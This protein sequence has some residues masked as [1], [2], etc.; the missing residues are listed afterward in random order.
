MNAKW[1][2]EGRKKIS[3]ILYNN[4]L[5]N[6]RLF[7]KNPF[8]IRS[9]QICTSNVHTKQI[10]RTKRWGILYRVWSYLYEKLRENKNKLIKY[11]E[12][13][14]RIPIENHFF[15]FSTKN[16]MKSKTTRLHR[17]YT[18]FIKTWKYVANYKYEGSL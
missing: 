17:F 2:A 11:F 7:W 1:A 3:Y 10:L 9:I 4:K 5:V 6:K 16:N 12:I 14:A 13:A 18:H 15:L 8:T